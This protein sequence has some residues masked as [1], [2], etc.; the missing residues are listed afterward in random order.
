MP[1]LPQLTDPQPQVLRRIAGALVERNREKDALHD[2]GRLPISQIGDPCERSLWAGLHRIGKPDM[3]P[4]LLA[5]FAHGNAIEAHVVWLLQ[6]AGYAV[7]TYDP[8][9]GSQW[10]VTDLD[11]R[12]SGRLDGHIVLGSKKARERVALLEIKSANARQYAVLIGCGVDNWRPQYVDQVQ[13]YMG[14]AELEECLFVVYNKN[15]FVLDGEQWKPDYLHVE[16]IRFDASR[17][18]RLR[19]KAKRVVESN[20]IP[21]RPAKATS[22][23]C[24]FCKYCDHNDWCWS[25]TTG[26]KFDE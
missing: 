2:S 6:I 14:L 25:A 19:A 3:D 1:S 17:F 8:S 16:R 5:V 26:V 12:V 10:R 24:G 21:E 11:E 18:E 15:D 4:H 23:Y 20:D 22:Q 9:T 13:Y 7:S